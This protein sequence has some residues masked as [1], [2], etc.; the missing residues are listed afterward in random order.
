MAKIHTMVSVQICE[1]C[2]KEWSRTSIGTDD[3]RSQRIEKPILEHK[4]AFYNLDFC[5]DKCETEWY[6]QHR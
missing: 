4:P 1:T 6:V 5:S 2:D 3:W